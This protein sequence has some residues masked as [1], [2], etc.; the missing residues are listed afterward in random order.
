LSLVYNTSTLKGE[1][2]DGHLGVNTKYQVVN[3]EF[4]NPKPYCELEYSKI[5]ENIH[6]DKKKPWINEI[7]HTRIELKQVLYLNF[8][9]L[10]KQGLIIPH[11]KV[12]NKKTK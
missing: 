9:L 6:I 3:F 5:V 11:C 1:P 2:K 4:F 12:K 8:I 10:Q 7:P